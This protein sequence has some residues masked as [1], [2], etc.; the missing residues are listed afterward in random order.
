MQN[1]GITGDRP[2]RI[3]EEQ[4]D[5]RVLF[6]MSCRQAQGSRCTSP[7]LGQR[8][9]V[10]IPTHQTNPKSSQKDQ[11]GQGPHNSN[12]ALLAK[13]GVVYL[14]QED[15]SDRPMDSSGQGRSPRPGPSISPSGSEPSPDG[16]AVERQLLIDRGLSS[17][18]ITTLL[19]SR[20]KV[21]STIYL[22][23]WI[24]FCKFVNKPVNV[25]AP[26]D[27]PLILQFLQEGLNKHLRPSTIKVQISALSALYD[28][29]LA[30]HQ[31]IKR[32]VKA[33]SR[34]C[35]TIRSRV[36]PWDLN[37]VLNGLTAN[38]FEPL[39]DCS[40]KFLSYKLAFLLAITSAR[41]VS[42][43]RAFSIQTP[44]MTIR[45]DRVVLSP[46]PAFLPKVV[47]DFHRSQEV[48]LPSFYNTPTNDQELS[49]HSL[50]VRRVILHYIKVTE[51]WRLCN[52]LL[53]SFQG[54]TK[55]K[56][57]STQTIARWVKQAVGE[58]YRVK[59]M[60]P[61]VGFGAHSTRAVA[62][63]WAER[64]AVSIDQ[65]C[66]AATWSTPHTF[67]RHYRLQLSSTEDLTFGRSVLQ[68]VV[69]P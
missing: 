43:I 17:E 1:V 7:A 68:A 37:L 63:S 53:I 64:A 62:T 65:I 44:Y 22:R 31:W 55:G 18:V 13:K 42:E 61:P 10:R 20:K 38:P 15:V 46:D 66:R 60:T 36:P 2:L 49:L 50:D 11:A 27:I 3:A 12:S 41:R 9:T 69:P 29:K 21:T 14:A 58:C 48:I 67:F 59:N 57:A 5:P 47:T 40:I 54:K 8:P 23:T 33:T 51:S 34:L 24:A 35:P 32:F 45:E 30:E 6:P 19:A 28:Y 16:M 4:K 52:S 56:S 25:L 39:A 26:P